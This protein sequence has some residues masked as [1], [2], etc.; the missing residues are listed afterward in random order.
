MKSRKNEGKKG[1]EGKEIARIPVMPSENWTQFT[2]DLSC[3][4]GVAD[5]YFTYSGQ[6]SLDLMSFTFA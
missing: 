4:T 6:G 3:E 5:F 2:A 1:K